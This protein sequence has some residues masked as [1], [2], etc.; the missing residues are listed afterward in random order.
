MCWCVCAKN[1]ISII[2]PEVDDNTTW[3]GCKHSMRKNFVETSTNI[4][5]CFMSHLLLLYSIKAD[6]DTN[7]PYDKKVRRPCSK[8]GL[9]VGIFGDLVRSPL[10]LLS[11]IVE[12]TSFLDYLSLSRFENVS[13]L[14]VSDSD[15]T[16]VVL[17]RIMEVAM[18]GWKLFIATRTGSCLWYCFHPIDH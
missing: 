9:M 10:S 13:D 8:N 5:H 11:C 4:L 7:V 3:T 18:T 17:P 2:E 6:T 14:G 16:A 12:C 15:G 1:Y